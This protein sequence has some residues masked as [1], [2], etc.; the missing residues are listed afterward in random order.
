MFRLSIASRAKLLRRPLLS[1]G[2]AS[3]VL[4]IYIGFLMISN[5]KNQVA[6]QE[7]GLK[8]FRLDIEKRAA[9]LEYFFS[10]R[11]YDLR[12]LAASNSFSIYF[13]NKAL[14]MSEQYGL[15]VSLFAIDQLLTRTAADKK[16]HGNAIYD[17][18]MLANRNGHPVA[19]TL[20]RGNG[21]LPDFLQEH[22][23]SIHN[24]PTIFTDEKESESQ[25]LVAAPYVFRGELSGEV[26]AWLNMETLWN[27]FVDFSENSY[28]KGFGLITAD[29]RF[30]SP[31][32]FEEH[33]DIR[34]A[35]PDALRKAAVMEGGFLSPNNLPGVPRNILVLRIPIQ[36][37][38][39]NLVTWVEKAELFGAMAPW[40]LLIGAGA[41][42]FVLLAGTGLLIRV[43]IRHLILRAQFK[44]AEQQQVLLDKQVQK[45]SGELLLAN[46]YLKNEI[47]H[48]KKAETEL[49][50][51]YN[52]LKETQAQLIQTGKLASIGELSAGVA[53]ELNQPLMVIRGTTQIMISHL[54]KLSS[55]TIEEQLRNIERNTKRMMNIID[56]LRTFSRQSPSDYT[57]V[58]L[59]RVMDDALLMVN[60]QLRLRGI[61]VEKH[62]IKNPLHC[63]GNAN[64]LEQVFLNLIT[65]AR[66]A[67]TNRMEKKGPTGDFEGKLEIIIQPCGKTQDGVEILFKDNGAGIASQDIDKLFDPFFTTK[68]VGKGTGLG[69]SISYGIIKDHGGSIAMAHTS[70][71]GT[72]FTII[73]SK[74]I[75][76]QQN[77]LE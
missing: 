57:N 48:R 21:L 71:D 59:C 24:D 2:C 16:V 68:E 28:K 10:E 4:M 37:T 6:L 72:V 56:H 19:D 20:H 45:R 63:Y 32:N 41:M 31:H 22:L 62:F 55:G 12:S 64:Q 43:N 47:V 51:A 8:R 50:G 13:T 66:D 74:S 25:V 30:V 44:E 46:K 33:P 40:Q 77:A 38:R 65:N 58:N 75:T 5:Y 49:V 73:L 3:L 52:E 27:Y 1:I 76:K 18:I 54:Q 67:I 61:T 35:E 53:H 26:I 14:G 17:R 15:K 36:N 42:A 34:F 69:L 11:K 7:S 39:L 60:E 70:S 23:A 9:S 29:G